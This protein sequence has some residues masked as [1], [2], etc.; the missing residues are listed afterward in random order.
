MTSPIHN[1]EE[2]WTKNGP[3]SAQHNPLVTLSCI[4]CAMDV[5]NI[6]ARSEHQE[7]VRHD[8]RACPDDAWWS[9]MGVRQSSLVTRILS[10]AL[11]D[12]LGNNTAPQPKNHS[13]ALCAIS[14]WLTSGI[15]EHMPTL[16]K[17]WQQV[18][19]S[20]DLRAQSNTD[21]YLAW[22]DAA[23]HGSADVLHMM[24]PSMY[25]LP[26]SI[27]LSTLNRVLDAGSADRSFLGELFQ[28]NED[29]CRQAADTRDF[30]ARVLVKHAPKNLVVLPHIL[31]H[32]D[33]YELSSA[34]TH[35][36]AV[37][38]LDG[39]EMLWPHCDPNHPSIRE[40]LAQGCAAITDDVRTVLRTS[41]PHADLLA[42]MLEHAHHTT[43][44]TPIDVGQVSITRQ[45]AFLCSPD[46][47]N[48]VLLHA[49]TTP[50]RHSSPIW[51]AQCVAM[52]DALTQDQRNHI[53]DTHADLL[54][55]NPIMQNLQLERE[56]AQR[57]GAPRAKKM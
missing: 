57:G 46:Q 14:L 9:L 7:R 51:V 19:I 35:A 34:L 10:E 4:A 1:W 21:V 53:V 43:Q 22:M 56:T 37:R 18:S 54:I 13:Q 49:L 12:R 45:Q 40:T 36:L 30:C 2:S 11:V 32:M 39:L 31:P 20:P 29:L 55:S 15:P 16:K 38:P 27:A 25:A 50:P 8:L 47:A 6:H 52:L 28:A 41:M 42:V 5:G 24:W 33:Q 17:W 3:C 48:T 26:D 44:D 23:A